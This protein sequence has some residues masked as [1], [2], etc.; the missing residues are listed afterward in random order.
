MSIN[1]LFADPN[2]LHLERISSEPDRI[3]IIV[4]TK[5][6]ADSYDRERRFL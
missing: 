2:L 3:T 6:N 5:S 1:P 4:K